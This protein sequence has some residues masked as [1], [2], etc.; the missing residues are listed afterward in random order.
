MIGFVPV[1]LVTIAS[2]PCAALPDPLLLANPVVVLS[3]PSF[4]F[5]IFFFRILIS[6]AP[7]SFRIFFSS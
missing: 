6:H 5:F 3:H 7:F 1:C 2:L 4:I